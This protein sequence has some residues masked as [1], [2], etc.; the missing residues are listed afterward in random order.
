MQITTEHIESLLRQQKLQAAKVS[1]STSESSFGA[2]F[3]QQMSLGSVESTSQVASPLP[4]VQ[5]NIVSQLLLSNA[6]DTAVT[7]GYTDKLFDQASGA[8]DM[9]ESYANVLQ[10]SG[11]DEGNLRDAYALLEGTEAQVATLKTESQGILEENPNLASLVNELEVLT[12]TEKMK[13][14][15]GDYLVS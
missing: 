7:S 4:T 6:D 1:T 11:V 3:A 2:A 13:F 14:N 8:L 9:W 5:S 15:R 12:T 10:E